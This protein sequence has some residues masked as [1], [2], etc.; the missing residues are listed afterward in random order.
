VM[1]DRSL[2]FHLMFRG[3]SH[4]W[5]WHT[6][7]GQRKSCW[8]N[9]QKA[10]VWW[11]C[12]SPHPVSAGF[13]HGLLAC[14]LGMLVA[15]ESQ[16]LARDLHAAAL[17]PSELRSAVL[18]AGRQVADAET[19]N[20]LLDA[21]LQLERI[22]ERQHQAG[23]SWLVTDDFFADVACESSSSESPQPGLLLPLDRLLDE[24]RR[25]LA[26]ASGDVAF[27]Q[28]LLAS[29]DTAF[30]RG[31]TEAADEA[32]SQAAMI[33]GKIPSA[34]LAHEARLRQAAVA[35]QRLASSHP[36]SSRDEGRLPPESTV[37]SKRRYRWQQKR[38]VRS[39]TAEP[40]MMSL[41]STAFDEDAELVF[42]HESGSIHAR[43]CSDGQAP[44]GE[45]SS[46]PFSDRLFPPIGDATTRA[47]AWAPCVDNDRLLSVLSIAM[48]PSAVPDRRVIHQLI[49]LDITSA[50]E[51]RLM[52]S[53]QLPVSEKGRAGRP[54][55][56]RGLLEE[57]LAFVCLQDESTEL[58]C[59]R[60][61]DG[62]LLWRRPLGLPGDSQ[63]NPDRPV[64]RTL[65]D[66]IIIAS[67]T[68]GLWAVTVTGDLAWVRPV[69]S[70][71]L[72]EAGDSP[73]DSGVAVVVASGRV[74]ARDSSGCQAFAYDI[75]TGRRDWRFPSQSA[76]ALAGS[77]G[78]SLIVAQDRVLVSVSIADGSLQATREIPGQPM[79]AP[80][81][82][83][84]QVVLPVMMSA[85]A[86]LQILVFLPDT[87]QMITEPLSVGADSSEGLSVA[88][89]ADWLLVSDGPSITAFEHAAVD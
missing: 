85:V 41:T 40:I 61:A 2:F 84:R 73:A 62:Q 30:E 86:E 8:A 14:V 27:C 7:S 59:V 39:D 69:G 35:K 43:R 50:A 53:L 79:G 24:M 49:C 9:L 1:A 57:R 77:S 71:D 51:G 66:M 19:P 22:A 28:T 87:L 45:R 13:F 11:G 82:V 89:N 44:W 10:R 42:W 15:G 12:P 5:P 32:W 16:A 25:Q 68:H 34:D 78:H 65:E 67:E 64:V 37:F 23:R 70:A 18:A 88:A 55:T 47:P 48:P 33:A 4:P 6:K 75:R 76:I 3:K 74:I 21:H 20:D 29:G 58:C 31:W 83:D 81:V 46:S 60:L 36:E 38:A 26:A 80:L 52:W 72:P 54:V 63:L 17:L 56:G